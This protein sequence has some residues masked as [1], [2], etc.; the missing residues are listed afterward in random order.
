MPLP[1]TKRSSVAGAHIPGV[2]RPAI[3]GVHAKLPSTP[4]LRAARTTIERVFLENQV[5]GDFVRID[6]RGSEEGKYDG[7]CW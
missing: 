2:N 4:G 5:M 3:L 6:N 7:I 1:E